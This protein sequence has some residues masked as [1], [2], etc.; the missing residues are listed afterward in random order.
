MGLEFE[1]DVSVRGDIAYQSALFKG[2]LCNWAVSADGVKAGTGI[3]EIVTEPLK[4]LGAL[5]DTVSEATKFMNNLALCSGSAGGG[6]RFSSTVSEHRDVWRDLTEGGYFAAPVAWK[7]E[8]REWRGAPQVT[9]GIPIGK[10]HALL[11]AARN[12]ELIEHLECGAT[13]LQ[14]QRYL[15]QQLRGG[16]FDPLAVARKWRD[17][18]RALDASAA[19]DADKAM[20]LM[21]LVLQ[22]I[23]DGQTQPGVDEYAKGVFSLVHRTDFCS[24]YAL[25]GKAKPWFTLGAVLFCYAGEA[26]EDYARDKLRVGLAGVALQEACAAWR[27]DIGAGRTCPWASLRLMAHGFSSPSCM[28]VMR[29][30][31]VDDRLIIPDAEERARLLLPKPSLRGPTIGEWIDSII[32]SRRIPAG[33]TTWDEAIVATYEASSTPISKA[34][35]AKRDLLSRGMCVLDSV[36]L[37]RLGARGDCVLLEFRRWPLTS[38]P[39]DYWLRMAVRLFDLYR[40]GCS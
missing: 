38:L 35:L 10:V 21:A 9:M 11:S 30:R 19:A 29:R 20:S 15:F 32:D 40:T 12:F 5:M 36:S 26:D 7:V 23:H 25:L 13:T 34:D 33:T 18:M 1:T 28:S 4:T 8:N 6:A 24:M 27:S 17:I 14:G 22:F 2:N 31:A 39:S 3:M 37:G 16:A